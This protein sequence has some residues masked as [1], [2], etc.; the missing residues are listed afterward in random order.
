MSA[1]DEMR[2]ILYLAVGDSYESVVGDKSYL[3]DQF[4]EHLRPVVFA[5]SILVTCKKQ[6][7]SFTALE[8]RWI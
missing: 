4:A 7:T 3:R 8:T 1:A 6:G 2:R 5:G